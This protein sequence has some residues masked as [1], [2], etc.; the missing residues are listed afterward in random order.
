[1]NWEDKAYICPCCGNI[2]TKDYECKCCGSGVNA[3]RKCERCQEYRETT[4]YY[5]S[6]EV[7]LCDKCRE[8]TKE[9]D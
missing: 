9:E 3:A 7:W 1:M 6:D 8:E 5:S 2:Q 4:K